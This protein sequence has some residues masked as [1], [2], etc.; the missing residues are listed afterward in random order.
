MDNKKVYMQKN[1]GST[2]YKWSPAPN[3]F[4]RKRDNVK[5]GDS[6]N[7]SC[8]AVA[9]SQGED[10]QTTYVYNKEVINYVVK[11]FA[12]VACDYVQ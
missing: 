10:W 9:G 11:H 1:V 6:P 12:Y 3:Q 7:T 2:L 4:D 8:T 5:K